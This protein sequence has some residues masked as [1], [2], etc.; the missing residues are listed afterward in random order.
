[1]SSSQM[2]LKVSASMTVRKKPV[3]CS[4]CGEL[5]TQLER[6]ENCGSEVSY[7]EERDKDDEK[8]DRSNFG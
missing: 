2:S 8:S 1:M 6:C 4:Q 5:R 3:P 7:K